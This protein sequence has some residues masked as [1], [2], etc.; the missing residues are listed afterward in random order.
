MLPRGLKVPVHLQALY[1]HKTTSGGPAAPW[2]DAPFSTATLSA[3]D[4]PRLERAHVLNPIDP[5]PGVELYYAQ[6]A[7]GGAQQCG[8]QHGMPSGAFDDA[9]EAGERGHGGHFW[10]G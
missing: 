8:G 10:C 2:S 6:R 7:G 9:D 5:L 4:I 3:A 1:T